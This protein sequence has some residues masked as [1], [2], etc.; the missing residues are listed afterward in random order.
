M[1]VLVPAFATSELQT[2]FQMGFLIYI[3]FALIDLA[4]AAILMA[5]GMIMVSPTLIS[6]PIKL[7]LFVSIGGWGLLMGTMA[8]RSGTT[9]RA[10][11]GTA[12]PGKICCRGCKNP[13][14][15][16]NIGGAQ[17]WR[18]AV[19]P[20]VHGGT[21]MS[22]AVGSILSNFGAMEALNGI[23]AARRPTTPTK[24]SYPLAFRSTARPTIRR[25]SSRR[26]GSTSRSTASP[27]RP[28]T[29]TR[30]VSLLQTAQGAV[31]QQLDHRA[32]AEHASRFRPPTA[33][34]RRRRRNPCKGS[35]RSSP[36]R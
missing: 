35:S 20:T 8:H 10:A 14:R 11:A 25:A 30:A 2:A 12:G 31:Q 9:R 22:G 7:L 26:R 32:E 3:P 1:L 34:R 24:P 15:L 18:G 17:G 23:S 5:L 16:T 13:G 27:R 33:P 36:A 4:V 21:H 28:R 6:F 19:P 29:R